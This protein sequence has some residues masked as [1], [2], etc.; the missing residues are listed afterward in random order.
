MNIPL[1]LLTLLTAH[2]IGDFY[3]Q[4]NNM[5]HNKKTSHTWLAA[6]G[7]IYAACMALALLVLVWF[8]GVAFSSNLVWI[9]LWTSCS[10]VAV[11]FLKM[12]TTWEEILS[13]S[14][15]DRIIAFIKKHNAMKLIFS[16]DQAVHF[17]SL[18]LAWWIWGREL[19]IGYYI[20]EYSRNITIAFGLLCILRPVGML[21]E[22]G[23]IWNFEFDTDESGNDHQD[24]NEDKQAAYNDKQ[25]AIKAQQDASRMIGYLER[26]V[27]FFLLLNGEYSTIAL[28]IAAKSIARFPEIKDAAGHMKANHYIIGTFLSLTAVFAITALLGLIP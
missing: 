12:R 26:I 24:A 21:V 17:A 23:L 4:T 16:I 22:S 25:K 5:A 6:H 11:D 7:I 13:A 15:F 20:Y 19:V 28:V 18:L 27:A 1:L 2:T 9:F 8:G 14:K 3:L 10:H